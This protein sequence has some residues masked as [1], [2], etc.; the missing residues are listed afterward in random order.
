[1]L[2]S[3]LPGLRDQI[4]A[5]ESG[6]SRSSILEN[7]ETP[8]VITTGWPDVDAALP[9]GGLARGVLHEWYADLSHAG[10]EPAARHTARHTTWHAPLCILIHLAHAALHAHP[11][12]DTRDDGRCVVWVG[13]HALPAPGALNPDLLRRSLFIHTPDADARLWAIDLALRNPAV[14]A[15]VADAAALGHAAHRRLQL[16]AAAGAAL[17]LL[18]RPPREHRAFSSA[19][20][21]WRITPITPDTLAPTRQ[22]HE[23]RWHV[24]LLR[25]K[26][27]RPAPRPHAWTIQR[28]HATRHLRLAPHLDR[29]PQTTDTPQPTGH[30]A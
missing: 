11:S 25:C 16:A 3:S 17:A 7:A 28:D 14:T 6:W 5:L 19:T 29:R 26:G 21:R 15:V 30:T 24:E 4:D 23:Q 8:A 20:T 9:R 1:M 12:S 27:M 2:K 22:P 10:A 13:D 18:T